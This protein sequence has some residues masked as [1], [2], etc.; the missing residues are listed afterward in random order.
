MD[1]ISAIRWTSDMWD[2]VCSVMNAFSVLGENKKKNPKEN[3]VSLYSALLP[4][5][6]LHP[7]ATIDMT[8]A[9]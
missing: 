8:M 4:P 2:Q 7:Y 9:Y 6:V 3:Q 5:A 1:Y